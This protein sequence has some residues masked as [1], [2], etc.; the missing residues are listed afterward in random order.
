[1]V[2]LI[3]TTLLQRAA[4]LLGKDKLAVL[5]NVPEEL[6]DAWMSGAVD[7]PDSRLPRLSAILTK[8]AD[9]TRGGV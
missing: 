3:K 1:M 6:L 4:K 2:L 9:K 7:M 5:M 8:A